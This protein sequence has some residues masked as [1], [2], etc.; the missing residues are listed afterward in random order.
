VGKQ[1]V[2]VMAESTVLED[3]ETGSKS[4]QCRYFKAKVLTSHAKEEINE[5]VFDSLD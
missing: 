5:T 4:S 1:N 2:A 3:V